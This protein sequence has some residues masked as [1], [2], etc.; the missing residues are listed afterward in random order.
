MLIILCE[1]DGHVRLKKMEETMEK[2]VRH[3]QKHRNSGRLKRCVEKE[4][5]D[6]EKKKTEWEKLV[7]D[8]AEQKT[9]AESAA[10]KACAK[11]QKLSENRASAQKFLEKTEEKYKEYEKLASDTTDAEEE[12]CDRKRE[13]EEGLV[14]SE[15]KLAKLSLELAGITEANQKKVRKKNLVGAMEDTA[16][17]EEW[18]LDDMV[19]TIPVRFVDWY[20][21]HNY[22]VEWTYAELAVNLSPHSNI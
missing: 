15:K 8:L 6:E 2:A 5:E 11:F 16:L 20:V 9:A 14:G 18:T 22:K 12:V 13:A 3:R 19:E 10:G 1:F 21:E 7:S 4:I 17:V